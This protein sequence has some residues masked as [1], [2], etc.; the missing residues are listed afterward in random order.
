MQ[1]KHLCAIHLIMLEDHDCQTIVP[2]LIACFCTRSD[3]SEA[4]MQKNHLFAIHHSM[5]EHHRLGKH[6]MLQF[7]G[8]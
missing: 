4:S 7:V 2:L 5:L 6:Y 8:A 1:K 3:C